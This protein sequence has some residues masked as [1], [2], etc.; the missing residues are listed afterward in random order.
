VRPMDTFGHTDGPKGHFEIEFDNVRVPVTNVLLGDGRGFEISQGR[1]GPGRIHHCMRAIGQGERALSL[2]CKRVQQRKAF[3]K[4]LSQFDTILQDIAKSRSSL[5][6]ARML[7]QK[8]ADLMDKL[9]NKDPYTR[10]LLSLVKAVVPSTVAA[11]VDRAM[12]AHGGLGISS[13]TPLWVMWM[14]MR[15]LRFA[16]GPDEVHWRTAAGIE[17]ERQ[18]NSILTKE[19]GYNAVDRSQ[20]W[21]RSTD[22]IS[23]STLAKL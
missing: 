7:T 21:R 1:L 4:Q 23:P 20:V 3:G 22:A 2:M 5:D 16:D 11:V 19:T 15:A 9:G 12:Q 10:Q 6:Q 13:D 8:A 18:K 17:L 14:S